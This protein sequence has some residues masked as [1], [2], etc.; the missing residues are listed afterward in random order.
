MIGGVNEIRQ[1]KCTAFR[2]VF[3][4]I[5]IEYIYFFPDADMT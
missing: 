5:D 3:L 1:G 2:R 4:N